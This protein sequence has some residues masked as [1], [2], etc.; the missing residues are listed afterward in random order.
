MVSGSLWKHAVAGT[1]VILGLAPAAE[2]AADYVSEAVTAI[3]ALNTNWYKKDTGLW[4][5]AWWNSG[6]AL[7]TLADFTIL[8]REQANKLN[9]GGII[10]N[11]YTNA[12]KVSVQ[13]TKTRA[14]DG[15]ITTQDCLNCTSASKRRFLRVRGF[16]NF[17]NE[18]YDDEGWWAL[19]LIHAYDATGTEKYLDSAVEIFA[20]MQTG[21]GTPC[22]GGIY[23]SKDRSYVNAIANELYLSVAAAL[24][25][26]KSSRQYLQIAQSQWNWFWNSGMIN[27]QWLINDGLDSSCKNNGLTTWSYNQGVVLGGLVELFYASGNRTYINIARN[28]ANAAIEA[29]SNGDGILVE[30]DHCELQNGHC[31]MD[32]Q[33]FKGIFVRN[34]RYLNAVVYDPNYSAFIKRNADSIWSKDRS[35]DNRLGVA[36]T[37]PYVT[38]TGPSHSSALDCLVAALA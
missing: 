34:L 5:A 36:W 8:Q 23:W 22:N 3:G 9:I 19:G 30:A 20:D 25:N 27:S 13:T 35:Q 2:S 16:D 38:A 28:I 37:G 7:T 6:N 10:E 17:L 14:A 24:A 21:K 4:N 26:R 12:Q 32:G 11:T 29:L 18:Y 33:Q 31:G 1:A 15:L